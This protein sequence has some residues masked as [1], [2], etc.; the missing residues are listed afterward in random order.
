MK[1]MIAEVE[2]VLKQ[3]GEL[4]TSICSK[5]SWEYVHSGYPRIDANT[6]LC[7][8]DGPEKDVPHY[9]ADVDDI[10][11]LLQSFTIEKIRHVDY[12]YMNAKK[13]DSKYYY[14]NGYKK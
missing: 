12:C 13:Q 8:E 14:V 3:G 9:Y 4:Y 7:T 11:E 10:L 1:R 5:S 2:R 6:L